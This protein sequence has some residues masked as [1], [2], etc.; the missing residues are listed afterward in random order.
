MHKSSHDKMSW[1]KN[2]YLNDN[3]FLDILDVGSLD[4]S[5]TNYN[6]KSIFNSSNW[7]YQGLDFEKGAN[8]D[9]VVDDIYNWYEVE[10]NNYDV[11]VSGQFFEH[12]GFFWLTMAEIDRVL[13]PGG[14]C[15]IIAPSGGP[16]H[17][18]ADTDCYRFYEDGMSALA[19]YVDFEVIHV[20]TNAD[21]KP[22]C[23]TCLV[24]KKTGS[25]VNSGDNLKR[26]MN[27]LENKLDA[28]LNSI[29][30]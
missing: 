3:D 22:W 9:I 8:V 20:S 27:N 23:D 2:T 19:K 16:K 6:Y 26:R 11:V 1:F 4:T 30:K 15:C 21:D 29:K 24:A 5:G 17:G 12:L 18:D 10:D 13:R 14:F 7:T 25:L 28:I